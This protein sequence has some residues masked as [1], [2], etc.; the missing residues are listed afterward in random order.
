MNDV[1]REF[2]ISMAVIAVAFLCYASIVAICA[3]LGGAR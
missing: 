2:C 3:I 1:D